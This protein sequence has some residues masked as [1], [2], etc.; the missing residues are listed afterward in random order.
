MVSY[1]YRNSHNKDKRSH[2]RLI[3]TMEIPIAV[4]TIKIRRSHDSLIFAREVPT[5]RK[6]VFTLRPGPAS[7]TRHNHDLFVF[8][9][10]LRVVVQSNWR[11]YNDV[12][13]GAMAS[14]ITSLAIVYSTVYSGT[15]QRNHQSSASLTFVR[16]IHRRLVNSPHKWPGTRK[17]FPF[18]DVIMV[19]FRGIS[20]AILNEVIWSEKA[21]WK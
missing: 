4:L 16:G 15:D 19:R 1:W 7:I 13:M 3:S 17:M 12:M 9:V 20:I 6:T 5:Q 8:T 10:E 18:D 11:H 21:Y 2:N 14:Q